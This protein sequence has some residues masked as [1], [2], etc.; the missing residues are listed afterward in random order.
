MTQEL[1]GQRV[2]ELGG[3][4]LWR[5]SGLFNQKRSIGKGCGS[6]RAPHHVSQ[7]CRIG[8]TNLALQP[9][10]VRPRARQAAF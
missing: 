10:F 1:G 7:S 8:G 6:T 5:V 9:N 2:P 4:R 3:T